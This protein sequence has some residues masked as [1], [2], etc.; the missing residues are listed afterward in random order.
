M[1]TEDIVNDITDKIINF[2]NEK[3][4]NWSKVQE[5]FLKEGED[6]IL[7]KVVKEITRRGYSIEDEP[8]HLVK[9]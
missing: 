5:I 1:Q 9:F 2:K 3:K 8:F 7:V 4:Y 6:K